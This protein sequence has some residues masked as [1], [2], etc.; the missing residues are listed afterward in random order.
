MR[1]QRKPFAVCLENAGY[2]ASLIV[3]KI[4]RVMPDRAAARDDMVRIVDESGDDY[5]YH[6]SLFAFV[7]FPPAV[8]KRIIA[9]QSAA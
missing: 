5:L 9:M 3:G 6:A 8:R 7:D 2:R 1:A 4:Y